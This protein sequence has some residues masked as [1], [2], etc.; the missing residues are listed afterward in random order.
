MKELKINSSIMGYFFIIKRKERWSF[1]KISIKT[2]LITVM[3]LLITIPLSILGITSY[4]GAKKRMNHQFQNASTELNNLI[5]A[6]TQS[7]FKGHEESISM[8]SLNNNLKE[9]LNHPEYEPYLKAF[10]REYV[11]SHP[12]ASQTMMGTVDGK[13]FIYPEANLGNDYD[14]RTRDWYKKAIEKQTLIWTDPYKGK[15]SG[16]FQISCSIPVYNHEDSLVGV[17]AATIP[18]NKL[19]HD[20]NSIKIG[21][22]GYPY[23]IDSNKKFITHKDPNLIGTEIDVPQIHKVLDEKDNGIVEYNYKEDNGK[24]Y[25]KFS[26]YTKIPDMEWT[27]LSSIYADEVKKDTQPI[28][29]NTLIMAILSIL[30]ASFVAMAFANKVTQPIQAIVGYMNQ[31]K[32]GDFTVQSKVHSKDEIGLLS[33]NFNIMI[34]NV[35]KLLMETKVLSKEAT[36]AATNLAATGEESSASAE[37]IAKVVEEIAHGSSAQA[38][39]AEKS[40]RIASDLEDKFNFLS[41]N[42]AQMHENA[43]EIMD[44]N[45]LGIT[46]ID[47]LKE[48]TNLNNESISKIEVAIHQLNIKANDIGGISEVIRSIAEQTNLLALNAS[49]EAARAGEAGRGFAVVAD[50]IRKLAEGSSNATD[51]IRVI[52]EDIQKESKNTVEIMNE[53][54]NISTNQTNAVED[55][56]SS[57]HSIST[58]INSIVNNIGKVNTFIH[59]IVEDKNLIVQSIENISA[60]SQET[61]A[62]TEEATASVQQQAMAVEEVAKSA[63]KLNEISIL[64]NQQINQFKIN[65]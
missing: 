46:V 11:D 23:L 20:I 49:I 52:I 37:E 17:I 34:E 44:I 45:T 13:M 27:V 40:A 26:V 38:E 64:L 8:L 35:R 30:I 31:V 10:L 29:V 3:L 63:E 21:E 6:L 9:I 60:V 5:K 53:V 47:D 54:K 7:Y 14:P 12:D 62:A 2:K 50:E 4:Q 51:K 15:S 24:I 36:D 16:E 18:L 55:V 48:K 41:K 28:L 61:A 59:D 22:K 43:N 25:K 19:S 57:F 42:S 1:M 39:D 58:S 33:D 32:A 56:N 65:I